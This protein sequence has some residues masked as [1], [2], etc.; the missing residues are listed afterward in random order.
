MKRR[1]FVTVV[2]GAAILASFGA[3]PKIDGSVNSFQAFQTGER[4][5]E[6]FGLQLSTITPRLMA[7]FEGA[8]RQSVIGRSSSRPW[9]FWVGR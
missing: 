5:L 8:L 1:K 2:S 4:K 7:D 9:A 3:K 6:R